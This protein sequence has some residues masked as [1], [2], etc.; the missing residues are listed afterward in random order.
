MALPL[1]VVRLGRYG[2]EGGGVPS[3]EACQPDP[4][5]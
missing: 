3:A 1:G 5:L 4:T 2:G